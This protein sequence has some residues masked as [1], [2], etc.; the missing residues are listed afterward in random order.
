MDFIVDAIQELCNK[1]SSL[2]LEFEVNSKDVMIDK[3]S[4]R[5]FSKY[6]LEIK[7]LLQALKPKN[8]H[9]RTGSVLNAS[10]Q[11]LESKLRDTSEI[12]EKNISGS[13]VRLLLNCSYMLAEMEQSTK[14]I[15]EAVS[16]LD[17]SNVD[18][19][20][21]L[22][23][24]IDKLV[25][26]M[27]SM[28]FRTAAKTEAI[29][30]EVEKI[31]T[32]HNKERKHTVLQLNQ[33]AEAV[34]VDANALLV[35]NEVQQLKQEK[36]ELEAQKKHAEALQLSQLIMFLHSSEMTEE[37]K[38]KTLQNQHDPFDSFKCPLCGE[39]MKDPVAIICGHSFEHN[40]ISEYFLRG[41][42]TC[43]TCKI[44]LHSLDLTPNISLRNSIQEWEQ[45]ETEKKLGAA[46][47]GV[48][49][50]QPDSLNQA[51]EDLL[52]LLE[53]PRC[54]NAV[55]ENG[56]VSKII[57]SLKNNRVNTKT[58]LKCLYL[59]ACHSDEN[60]EAIAEAGGIY[61]IVK[62]CYT[63]EA[64][65]EAMALLLELSQK[66]SLV[67]KI[68]KVNHCISFLVSMLQSPHPGVSEKA[69]KVVHK[70]SSNIHLV[71]EMAK[72]GHFQPFLSHFNQGHPDTQATMVA[73][74]L[75]MRLNENSVNVLEQEHFASTLVRFLSSSSPAYRSDCLQCIKK[76]SAYPVIGKQFLEESLT[77][78]TM[79]RI[80]S[81]T[82][83][84]QYW[85]H[86]SADVLTSFVSLTQLSD[87]KN[88]INLQELQSQHNIGLILQ[89]ALESTMQTKAQF[90]HLLLALCNKSETAR[91][92]IRMDTN[93]LAHLFSC[94][95]AKH[96]EVRL[97]SLKLIYSTSN[98]NYSSIPLPESH[99][100]EASINS[101][102]MILSSSHDI[103]ERSTAAGII[104]LLPSNDTMV[105]ELL[106]KSDT[107]KAIREV[108]CTMDDDIHKVLSVQNQSL[109]ENVLGA[110]LRFAEPTKP[111]LHQQLTE[112]ELYPSLIGVLSRGSSLAK[113]RTALA[114]AHLSRSTNQQT[115]R[116]I[117]ART[118]HR[119]LW[120][121]RFL[122]RISCS[123]SSEKIKTSKYC[124]LHGFDCSSRRFCL[125]KADAVR[126][127]I[128]TLGETESGAAEAALEAL[129][130]LLED[131]TTRQHA[132]KAIVENQGVG[133]ILDV[134][135]KGPLPA[136]E[137]ALDIFPKIF[138][139]VHNQ[140]V[141]PQLQRARGVFI[142]LLQNESLKKKVAMVLGQM[143]I[144]PKQSSYF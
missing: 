95:Q 26:E 133:G 143:E 74:F 111:E 104:S 77:I 17:I 44:D 88:N 83:S 144:I 91:S 66:E 137:K 12:I 1:I 31:T 56:L 42:K 87:F 124:A 90:L 101:V 64:N 92:M 58:V 59:L 114:L 141:S 14:E 20:L 86:I 134:L 48:C 93:A 120:F 122:P 45:R 72:A 53:M 89:L 61:S 135:E 75:K 23:S 73:A 27:S 107:L 80:L 63:G 109:L 70:L 102:V 98:G 30:L 50:D 76:L 81:F 97:V 15:A 119:H 125:I 115:G 33:I 68:G 2:I 108:I 136:K 47:A 131:S 103:E 7:V 105:D 94:L 106:Q 139:H 52:V 71:I 78:P 36:V 46:L 117:R 112:L 4:F 5:Q 128:Q 67:E 142:H 127:L 116:P 38:E 11:N 60:K 55:T 69:Q 51:F 40:A 25:K 110:L 6:I 29:L 39:V 118:S 22:K 34:G 41:E 54:R 10:L 130:T 49:S 9:A 113:Q 3:E 79:L 129:D 18:E 57:L 132:A 121:T 62:R 19:T 13:K 37:P 16:F 140:M 138:E 123:C 24:K 28:E 32:S 126:P 84:D 99:T 82:G 35:R 85:K 43:P 100:K 21:C 96:S 65:P 8:V